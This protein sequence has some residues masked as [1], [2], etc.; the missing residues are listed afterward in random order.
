MKRCI[1]VADQM[2]AAAIILDVLEDKHFDRR[3]N[4]YAELGFQP[5]GDPDN[6]HRVFVPRSDVQATLG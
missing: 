2:G 3:W 5:P 1:G 4:F 6:L